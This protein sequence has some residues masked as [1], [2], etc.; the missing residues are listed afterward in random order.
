MLITASLS[1]HVFLCLSD[2]YS[3]SFN[4]VILEKGDN[5]TVGWCNADL[6]PGSHSA[7]LSSPRRWAL[8]QTTGPAPKP[9]LKSCRLT[10][11][12]YSSMSAGRLPRDLRPQIPTFTFEEGRDVNH[13]L[14]LEACTSSSPTRMA[15]ISAAIICFT[16]ACIL[17][18]TLLITIPNCSRPRWCKLSVFVSLPGVV[19]QYGADSKLFLPLSH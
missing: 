4:N 6:L 15:I 3:P 18:A 16:A 1:E 2:I 8:V 10:R 9:A 17:R 14:L 5:R 19:I 7:F 11:L 13:E 12:M